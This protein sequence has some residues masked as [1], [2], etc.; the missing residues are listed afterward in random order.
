MHEEDAVV[1]IHHHG[2]NCLAESLWCHNQKL[3]HATFACSSSQP[4]VVR[5]AGMLSGEGELGEGVGCGGS[6]VPSKK[7]IPRDEGQMKL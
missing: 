7:W 5:N 1:G 2:P 4:T 3:E 6:Q